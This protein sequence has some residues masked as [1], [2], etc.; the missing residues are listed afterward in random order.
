MKT[1]YIDCGMGAAGDMLTAALLELFPHPEEIIEKLN[2][3]DIPHVQF[4]MEK[5]TKCG[6]T[7]THVS[8]K[9]HGHEEHEHSHE[10]HHHHEH[11]HSHNTLHGIEHILSH[12]KIS[13]KIKTDVMNV[14]SLIA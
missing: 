5:S 4:S 2:T 11:T 6:I 8:V 13:E 7:G 10:N 14:Y 12:M 1:L 3:F 9:V